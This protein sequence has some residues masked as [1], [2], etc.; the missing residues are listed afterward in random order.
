MKQ[1]KAISPFLGRLRRLIRNYDE[2]IVYISIAVSI[3]IQFI[4]DRFS[5]KDS[6]F[7]GT[8]YLG[9]ISLIF[10]VLD[11][12]ATIE[13]GNYRLFFRNMFEAKNEIFAQIEKRRKRKAS[14]ESLEVHIIGLKLRAISGIIHEM[15]NEI[16][17]GRINIYNTKIVIYYFDPQFFSQLISPSVPEDIAKTLQA[18]YDQFS[19]ITAANIR[20]LNSY[21]N[22]QF[23]SQKKIKIECYT[24]D[25]FPAFWGFGIDKETIFIG[26]F[27]WS[28]KTYTLIGPQNP[29]VM[30]SK[31]DEISDVVLDF[32]YN[33]CEMFSSW[34]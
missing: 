32:H 26:P 25:S 7:L 21:N 11:M 15:M 20:E 33:R 9:V 34:K 28:N 24:Y 10:I 14:K 30:I 12:K 23:F 17:N 29:C 31:E 13:Q 3:I 8:I 6:F 18:Q 4:P 27:T 2:I 5:W 19:F 22:D 1:S 16:R